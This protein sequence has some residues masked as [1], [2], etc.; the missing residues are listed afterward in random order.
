MGR[1]V[2]K[3]ASLRKRCGTPGTSLMPLGAMSRIG[4]EMACGSGGLEVTTWV[5]MQPL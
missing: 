3:P 2:R 5:Q 1:K 4:T